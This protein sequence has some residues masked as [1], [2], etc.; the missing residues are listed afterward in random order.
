MIASQLLTPILEKTEEEELLTQPPTSQSQS[1][2]IVDVST[3]LTASQLVPS[4]V[5]EKKADGFC[6]QTLKKSA[7]VEGNESKD[8]FIASNDELN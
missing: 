4:V 8:P 3:P 5:L 6:I 1:P 2:A 7:A